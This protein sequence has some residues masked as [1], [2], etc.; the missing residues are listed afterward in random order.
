MKKP[1]FLDGVY[2]RCTLNINTYRSIQRRVV[3]GH[4][5]SSRRGG[6]GN[7]L[8][9]HEGISQGTWMKD[10]WIWAWSGD[11]LWKWGDRLGGG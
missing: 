9:D 10:P 1:N 5:A 7:W 4:T 6:G 2:Q 3:T 8:K 11:G